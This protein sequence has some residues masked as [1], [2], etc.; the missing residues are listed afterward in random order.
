[1]KRYNWILI[2]IAMISSFTACSESSVAQKSD[3]VMVNNKNFI[4]PD[5]LVAQW[6]GD[7]TCKV[8]F[9]PTKVV[10]Y[11]VKP[12]FGESMD[13]TALFSNDNLMKVGRIDPSKYSILLFLIADSESYNFLP[14]EPKCFFAPYLA[15][16]FSNRKESVMV[17][18]SFNCEKWAIVR[19]GDVRT[20][21]YNC[22]KELLRYFKYLLP[23]D[24]YINELIK[25]Q[26]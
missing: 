22:Q 20:F 23:N 6:L 15:Y 14:D 19:N 16:E 2:V 8:L 5:S 26:K 11:Q 18:I 4:Q 12:T 10:C 9:A 3:V 21:K 7:S 1:M 13:S 25:Y 24:S 17:Y